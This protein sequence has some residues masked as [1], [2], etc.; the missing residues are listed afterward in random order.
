MVYV[1]VTPIFE[2][3]DEPAHFARAYGIAEGQ[4]LLKDHPRDLILFI[5]HNFE[6]HRSPETR[7]LVG[8]LNKYK[9]EDSPSRIPNIAYNT[10]LYSPV[11][12]LF[13][14]TVIKTI[15]LMGISDHQLPL[16]VY[17]CRVLS[18]MLFCLSLAV[19]FHICPLL[20]WPI[21]WIAA[22]PMALS[23]ASVVS[24]DPIVFCATIFI[25]ALA[26]GK[27][28]KYFFIIGL[29]I[30]AC[31]LLLT[32]P[33]YF[34]VLLVPLFSLIFID[35]AQ[36]KDKGAGIVLAI[37]ISCFGMFIWNFMVIKYEIY[38]NSLR[39]IR[40]FAEI[41]LDPS[42]QLSGILSDPLQ[43]MKV[44]WNTFST[45]GISLAHQ[46]VG[47]LGWLDI[48][49]PVW[50]VILWGMLIF[51][52]I[53]M[54]EKPDRQK[55]SHSNW[56]GIICISISA[57]TAIGLIVSA[58]M[59]WMPVG[60]T[61]VNLQGRYFHPIMALLFV[62]LVLIK[63]HCFQLKPE[64]NRIGAFIMLTAMAVLNL[65]SVVTLIKHYEMNVLL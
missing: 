12:Y 38:Q 17:S 36:Q 25:L 18:L 53:F 58:Y 54:T 11:P 48:P 10:S 14:A 52:P 47:V 60:C 19:S 23:Q 51:L 4:F 32:K 44:L 16:S 37:C 63:P 55:N 42:K 33:P 45:K 26:I 56:L 41:T 35:R 31:F 29:T 22:T 24:T 34:P 65:L 13:H 7:I 27:T 6:A 30:S 57:L 40:F 9:S 1:I 5:L 64:F 59:I 8:Y 46:M 50:G 43:L 61:I 39:F 28:Q 15:M 21:F 62:G 3:P 20:S 2:A 49:L